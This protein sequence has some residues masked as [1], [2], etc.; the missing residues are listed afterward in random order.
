MTHGMCVY[1]CHVAA[2]TKIGEYFCQKDE[3]KFSL[4]STTSPSQQ[5]HIINE[6]DILNRL[7]GYVIKFS[8]M[9]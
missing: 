4:R 8:A 2:L 9:C 1:V 7:K 6:C 5:L 3:K